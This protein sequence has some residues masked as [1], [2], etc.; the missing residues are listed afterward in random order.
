MALP[1]ELYN[2]MRNAMLANE[3]RNVLLKEVCTSQKHGLNIIQCT[4]FT[5]IKLYEK[6]DSMGIQE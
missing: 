5:V 6:I 2:N 3:Q 1:K 4:N